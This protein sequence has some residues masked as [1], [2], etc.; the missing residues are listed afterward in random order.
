[1]PVA[2]GLRIPRQNSWKFKGLNGPGGEPARV[3]LDD[4]ARRESGFLAL[5]GRAY[6]TVALSQ[7]AGGAAPELFACSGAAPP[8]VE[9]KLCRLLLLLAAP[10]LALGGCFLL[11][12]SLHC[13]LAVLLATGC[14]LAHP[15]HPPTKKIYHLSKELCSRNVMTLHLGLWISRRKISASSEFY[16]AILS[17]PALRPSQAGH[18][19]VI[20]PQRPRPRLA[21]PREGASGKRS[22][23]DYEKHETRDAAR[24]IGGGHRIGGCIGRECHGNLRGGRNVSLSD[25]REMGRSL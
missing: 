6:R 15:M 8:W 4:K 20:P 10:F 9:A 14:T 18:R 12:L 24:A 5:T 13:H 3:P 25:R 21:T 7:N 11:G 17:F 2:L 16:L 19:T 23:R 1:M 22:R